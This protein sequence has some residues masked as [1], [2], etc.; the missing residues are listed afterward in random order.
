MN[1][2][3][4]QIPGLPL[5]QSSAPAGGYKFAVPA[6]PAQDNPPSQSATVQQAAAPQPATPAPIPPIVA[7]TANV[8]DSDDTDEVDDIWLE[9]AQEIIAQTVDD[10]Y[11]Q[12]IALARL[13]ADFLKSRY[14]K[15]IKLSE[16]AAA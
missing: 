6:V 15:E 10:P 13:R 16:D 14:G 12:T 5:P 8:A 7:A 1:S 11:S 4:S 9:K 2:D 3:Q